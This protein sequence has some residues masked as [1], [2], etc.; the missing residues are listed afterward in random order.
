M[1]FLKKET[2]QRQTMDLSKSNVKTPTES[3]PNGYKDSECQVVLEPVAKPVASHTYQH[4]THTNQK[5][6]ASKLKAEAPNLFSRQ[7]T[8]MKLDRDER[9]FKQRQQF[10]SHVTLESLIN[11]LENEDLVLRA[12]FVR[13]GFNSRNTCMMC[14]ADKLRKVLDVEANEHGLKRMNLHV[15]GDESTANE[16]GYMIFTARADENSGEHVIYSVD[17]HIHEKS[18]KKLISE[19]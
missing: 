19:H 3:M 9:Q 16:Q 7:P 4:E 6:I 10:Q 17:Y 18:D 8:I 2:V 12:S 1:S 14:S 13:P 11:V 5:A 15:A